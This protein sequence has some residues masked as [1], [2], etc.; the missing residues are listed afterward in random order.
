ML[1]R[2]EAVWGRLRDTIIL[3]LVVIVLVGVEPKDDKDEDDGADQTE[4]IVPLGAAVGRA[5][6][7][8]DCH[9]QVET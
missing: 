8:V 4:P 3:S 7:V 6:R 1:D 2:R 5:K 9:D